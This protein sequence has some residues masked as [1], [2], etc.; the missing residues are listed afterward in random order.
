MN[1]F[2]QSSKIEGSYPQESRLRDTPG[3]GIENK[4]GE[5]LYVYGPK[6]TN[7]TKDNS[8][9]V[10]GIDSYT[11]LNGFDCDGFYVPADRK[12][13]S[14]GHTI[15]G[16]KVVKIVDPQR[17]NVDIGGDTYIP[18]QPVLVYSRG[19]LN[20]PDPPENY[21]STDINSLNTEI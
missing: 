7:E 10:L 11:P 1:K 16:P 2:Q 15:N 5:K 4:T 19:Q 3:G 6:K 20:W 18:N 13:F 9:W 14:A 21:I 8:L 12:V 17:I